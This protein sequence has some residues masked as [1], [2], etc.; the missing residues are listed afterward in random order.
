ML[1]VIK[2]I[3]VVININGKMFCKVFILLIVI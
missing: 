2:V 3:N 1:Y